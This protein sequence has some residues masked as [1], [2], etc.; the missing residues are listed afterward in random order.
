MPQCGKQEGYGDFSKFGNPIVQTHNMDKLHDESIRFTNFH[1]GPVC[2]PTR[3][4]LLTGIDALQNGAYSPHGQHHLLKRD[5]PTIGEV[6]QKNGYKT[7]LY[8]RW[9]LG[10]NSIG[11]R[12]HERGFEDAVHFLR[13]GVWSIPNF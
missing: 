13:G 4:Q 6:F 11:Y 8:G 2:T 12:P 3:S 1:V 9:H 5:L 10:G 7:A